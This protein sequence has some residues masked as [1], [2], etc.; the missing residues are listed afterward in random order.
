MPDRGTGERSAVRHD[1]A[2][3]TP[4]YSIVIPTRNG[5]RTLPEVLAALEGQHGA[6]R[7]EVVVVDDGSTDGT[8]GRLRNRSWAIPV[9]IEDGV[10]GGPAVARNRGV[11]LAQG[12]RIGFLGDDTVPEPDWLASHHR[13]W[14]S[15]SRPA[16]LVVIGY[17][18]W[19]RRIRQSAFLRFLNEEGLQFGYSLIDDPE[20][21]PFNFFYTSNLTVG[22]E[23]ITAEP[24]DEGFPYPAW[25]DV[26][27][28]YR[29]QGR[30]MR[31]VYEPGARV[32][33]DHPTD[34]RRFCAR[35]EKAGYSA[36]VFWQGHPELGAFLG[37]GNEG[38]APLPSRRVQWARE[39]LVQALQPLPVP[40]RRLW[41]E[42]LRFHYLR[43]LHRGWRERIDKGG[44]SS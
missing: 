1:A 25:E 15:R 11:N 44:Q 13:A 32:A 35:Q 24:F 10:A 14:E 40:L 23:L 3:G 4:E 18:T 39:A 42:A 2:G 12:D 16:R 7:F 38:P 36:V 20:N 21:V 19:H 30:G 28:A 33:H 27:A 8:P 17:T 29:L 31:M 6:P 5:G 34:F 41:H 9:R 26:E 37:I 43:G 22:R